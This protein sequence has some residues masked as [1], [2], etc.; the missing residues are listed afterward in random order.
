[1]KTHGLIMYPLERQGLYTTCGIDFLERDNICLPF[2][3]YQTRCLDNRQEWVHIQKSDSSKNR[4]W[5]TI[6][7]GI[8]IKAR[9]ELICKVWNPWQL[10][11]KARCKDPWTKKLAL[12]RKSRSVWAHEVWG[13]RTSRSSRVYVGAKALDTLL[14][15]ESRGTRRGQFFRKHLI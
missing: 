3:P 1:M 9:E 8:Q 15:L 13:M 7:T 10:V 12:C 5:P 2:L 6:S 4:R 11:A 14:W